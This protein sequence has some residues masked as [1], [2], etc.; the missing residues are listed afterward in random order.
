MLLLSKE[1][2]FVC[3]SLVSKKL[4]KENAFGGRYDN[5]P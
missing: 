1:E 3:E 4:G 5:V 2:V